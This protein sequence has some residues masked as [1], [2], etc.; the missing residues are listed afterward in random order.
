MTMSVNTGILLVRVLF[1]AAISAHG[2]QKLFGWFGGYGLKGTGGFFQGLGFHPGVA[3]A[4]AAGLS[5]FV[6]GLLLVIGLFTP[7]GASAV[8]AA[9]IVAMVSV[10]L[11]GG[12][13]A[14]T[15]GIEMPFAYAAA[16]LGLLFTGGGEYSLDAQFGLTFPGQPYVVLGLLVLT[17]VG[18]IVTLAVRRQPQT[19][20][21]A[22][23]ISG[24]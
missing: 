5:E 11:K 22:E 12:F 4:A 17:I 16:A 9:M 2:A 8:L 7:L 10:H 24:T 18:A 6:G 3:F 1:G 13:F 21:S 14:A 19:Q 23:E 15:N 20:T